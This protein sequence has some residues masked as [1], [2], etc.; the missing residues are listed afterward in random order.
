MSRV[1]EVLGGDAEAPRGDLLDRRALRI[2]RAVGER[3]VAVRLLA[4]LAGVRLAADRVHGARQRGVRLAADRAERHRAGREPLDDVLGRFDLVERHRLAP[5]VGRH[6]DLEQAADGLR[7]RRLP[8][9]QLRIF[10]ERLER[11]LAHR[12]LQRRDGLRRPDMAFAAQPQRILAAELER[13]H[14]HRIVA[15]GA[16]VAAH[17]LLGDLLQADALDHRGRAGEVLVDEGAGQADRVEDLGA[18]IGLV[19]RDA[20]LGHHLED[21]LADRL[22]VAGDDLVGVDLLRHLAALVHVE[23]RV[24]GEVGIDRLGAVAGEAAEMMHLARLGRFHHQPD[25]G[26]QPL[27]DQMMMHGRRRQQRRDRDAVR[28]DL[29]VR[30][31]DDVVAAGDRRLG[32]VAEPVERR[33]HAGRTLFRLVGD[34]ERLGV[35]TVLDMAD[36]ADL[37]EIAIGQDR[38]AHLE[39][40]QPG[41]ADQV[42]DVRPRSDERHQAHHQ[43]LADRIDRRVG[44]LREVLLEIGVEQLRLVRHR[45]DRRVGAHRADGFLAGRRH[46][47]HQEPGVFLGVAEGL[48]AIEQ[49][50]VLAQR[51]RLDRR[52]VLEDELR[53]RPATACRDGGRRSPP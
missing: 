27:A 24:E 13:A 34:V 47:R 49:R 14:Q 36:R 20:H 19:G 52:Q 39:P 35:E 28:A 1:D 6:P 4:A 45:R 44:D 26:A 8:V 38:L 25:R 12:M 16:G 31:D 30:Q 22:D 46:R 37:L 11:A 2:A 5:G 15:E 32:A 21:A 29:A 53:V 42:E 43:L 48:L 23:Q 9:H 7:A 50:H 40:L 10:A 18:A 3:H 41:I 51:P 33:R 17:R